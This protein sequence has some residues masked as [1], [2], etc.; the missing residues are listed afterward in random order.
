MT[1]QPNL[2]TY[3]VEKEENSVELSGFKLFWGVLLFFVF[4]FLFFGV[5]F[6]SLTPVE[7]RQLLYEIIEWNRIK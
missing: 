6:F 5:F 1:Q 2:S 4:V 3:E 7:S